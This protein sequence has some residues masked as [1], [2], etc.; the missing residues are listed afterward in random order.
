GAL[1]MVIW[2]GYQAV[3]TVF[4]TADASMGMMATVNLIAIVFLSGT[5][6]KLTRDYLAQ[7]KQGQVPRFRLSDYPEL[8]NR[9]EKQI[10]E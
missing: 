5:V 10:W 3:I 8:E 6:V 9:V 4:N 1:A 2:G 7:R